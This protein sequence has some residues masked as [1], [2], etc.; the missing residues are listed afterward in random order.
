MLDKV[1]D[2]YAEASD[3]VYCRFLIT[4]DDR[5]TL[6]KAAMDIASFP[7][8]PIGRTEAGIEKW[9]SKDATPD[10]RV[11]VVIQVWGVLKEGEPFDSILTKFEKELSYR[12]RQNI[13]IKPFMSVFDA[14]PNPEGRIDTMERIGHCGDGYEWEENRSGRRMIIVPTMVPDFQIERF[15]GYGRGVTGGNFW[16]MCKAKKT[17]MKA[18][19][20][21]LKAIEKVE[22]VVTPFWVCSAGSKVETRFPHIGGTTNHSFC[23]SLKERLGKESRIPNGVNFIPEIV[24]HGISLEA[25]RNAMRVGI[26]AILNMNDITMISAGNYSGRLGKYKISLREL[27]H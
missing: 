19:R 21:A 22:G 26:D 15:I 27:F 3:G 20:K 11:G 8:A 13:M 17:V 1:E 25:V 4:A 6:S 12:I 23:P 14:H 9:V 10:N 7:S 5:E 24:I 18:G 2:T 16:Y